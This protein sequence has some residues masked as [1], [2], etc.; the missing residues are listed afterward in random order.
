MGIFSRT[1]KQAAKAAEPKKAKTAKPEAEGKVVEIRPSEPSVKTAKFAFTLISPRVSEKAAILASKG[2]YVFN[3]PVSSNKVE[4]AKAIETFYK[5]KVVGVRTIR[6]M[7]KLVRRGRTAGI[8]N[9]WKKA[10]VTLKAGQKIEL[11]EGV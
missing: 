10:L 6:G 7:G 2:T 11:Y 5:V 1:T 3:V 4:V 9:R 8:R